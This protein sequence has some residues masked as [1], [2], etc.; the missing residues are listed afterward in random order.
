MAIRGASTFQV[1]PLRNNRVYGNTVYGLQLSDGQAYDNVI[2]ANAI[3]MYIGATGNQIGNNLIY[4]NTTAAIDHNWQSSSNIYNNTIYQPAGDAIRAITYFAPATAVSAT[5]NIFVLGAGSAF[6]VVA[7]NQA[8]FGSD[9]NLFHL[10]GTGKVA[11]FGATT[12]TNWT[13]WQFATGND[14]HG[15]AGDPLLV[16]PDERIICSVR[17]MMTFI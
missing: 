5:N 17:R 9:Y 4:A 3:G 10:T 16:D 6:N 12:F 1:V 2:Y 13:D 15:I 7:Q 11:T 14:R 8:V